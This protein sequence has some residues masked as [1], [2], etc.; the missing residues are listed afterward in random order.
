LPGWTISL[1]VVAVVASL[2]GGFAGLLRPSR[3]S[4]HV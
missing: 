3:S 4:Q 2:L 1:I